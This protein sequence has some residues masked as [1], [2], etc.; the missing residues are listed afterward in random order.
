MEQ[1]ATKRRPTTP[2]SPS[3]PARSI[4]PSPA[5]IPLSPARRLTANCRAALPNSFPSHNRSS[6]Q[7]RCH[8]ADICFEMDLRT[9]RVRVL[10]VDDSVVMRR[11]IES[12]LR[13]AGLEA[14][15]ILTSANGAEALASLETM[16]A[17]K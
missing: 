9:Q 1:H 6:A 14:T 16:A 17:R 7:A 13:H 12:A 15:E 10:I 11:I 4:S 2:T 5:T 3:V 8:L